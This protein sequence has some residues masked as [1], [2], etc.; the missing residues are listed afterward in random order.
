M[1]PSIPESA[2]V[3]RRSM[4]ERVDRDDIA[5]TIEQ[6]LSREERWLQAIVHW[7]AAEPDDSQA[8]EG[9]DAA[10]RAIAESSLLLHEHPELIVYAPQFAALYRLLR[11]DEIKRDL[12]RGGDV[13]LVGSG[14]TYPEALAVLVRPPTLAELHLLASMPSTLAG[15]VL[16]FNE[17]DARGEAFAHPL[18]LVRGTL[19]AVEPD[20]TAVDYGTRIAPLFGLDAS[21]VHY[22]IATLGAALVGSSLPAIF[23][24]VLW[25]RADPAV[26]YA[27][28]ANGKDRRLA[29]RRVLRQLA[30]H[31]QPGCRLVLTVGTG[32]DRLQ[33]DG[34]RRFVQEVSALLPTVGFNVVMASADFAGAADT[35]CVYDEYYGAIAGLIAIRE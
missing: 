24:T 32:N 14:R 30:S 3:S 9:G 20:T 1:R 29:T 33:R 21:T 5:R 6:W 31:L 12:R 27:P 23:D 25:N 4:V 22:E 15:E 7:S 28:S 16:A 10:L 2:F 35:A 8:L 13:L 19:T 26:I 34:R 17:R 11:T 18:P